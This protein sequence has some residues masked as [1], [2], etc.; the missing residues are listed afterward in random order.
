MEECALSESQLALAG[1]RAGEPVGTHRAAGGGL[2]VV[3]VCMYVLDLSSHDPNAWV[4]EVC[5]CQV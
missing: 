3:Y 5:V 4:L 2:I 1:E